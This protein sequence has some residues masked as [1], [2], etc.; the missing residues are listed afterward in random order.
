MCV[1]IKKIRLDNGISQKD[2]AKILNVK[3][4]TYSAWERLENDIPLDKINDLANYY[5]TSI[6]YL[7]GISSIVVFKTISDVNYNLL[8]E[9]LKN[10]RKKFNYTQEYVGKL[11][12]LPQTTYS[13]FENG[14]NVPTTFK[15]KKIALVY[16]ISIDY[17]VGRCDEEVFIKC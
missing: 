7:L 12:G 8:S 9:R 17:L 16:N 5:N 11:A 6:D 15:L 14:I 4:K 13:N 1:K 2:I 3:T 10:I